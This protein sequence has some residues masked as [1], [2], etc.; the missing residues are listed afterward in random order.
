MRVWGGNTQV[1]PGM[2]LAL[3]HPGHKFS[4]CGASVESGAGL[5]LKRL[6]LKRDNG[7]MGLLLQRCFRYTDTAYNKRKA[8]TAL[9]LSP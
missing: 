5:L 8:G 6:L 7:I 3:E 1:S 2:S 9:V 4:S